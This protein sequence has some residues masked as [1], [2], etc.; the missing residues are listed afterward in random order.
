MQKVDKPACKS[1]R[2]IGDWPGM[3]YKGTIR[4]GVV[5]LPP[6]ADLQ[7]GQQ[8]EVTPLGMTDKDDF[9]EMLLRISKKVSGL[10][11]DLA[12][13]HDHYLYGTPKR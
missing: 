8:V 12:Q 4:N 1:P 13:Q 11:T 7:E 3:S 5:I 2:P 10:P 9:T 6:G